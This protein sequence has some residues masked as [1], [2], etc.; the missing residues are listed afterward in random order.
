MIKKIAFYLPQFHTIP[1]NDEWWGKDFTEWTNVKKSQPQYRGHIQPE[2]P[3]NEEYYNLLD[4]EVQEKQAKLAL[5]YGID[6]F[7]YYHYWFDGKLLLEKPMENMLQNKNITLPFCICWANESWSRT[8]DGAESEVLIMQNYSDT[9]D[10]WKRHFDYLLPFFKDERYIKV[11]E[12]P[13]MI[14]YKPQ[15][16]ENLEE[17]TV[18]WNQLAKQNGFEGIHFGHQHVS[19][20]ED[21]KVIE[22][23]DFG[24]EFEPIYTVSDMYKS[25]RSKSEK[26]N[27]AITSPKCFSRNISHKYFGRSLLFDYDEVWSAILRREGRKNISPG[28]FV[29]WDNTPRRGNRSLVF[30]GANPKKFEKYFAK[31]VQRAKEEYHSDFIFI[32]AWNEWA[33]GAHLEPDEQHGYGYLEAVRAVKEE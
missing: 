8:W 31:Q 9:L 4:T 7:C 17:M 15:L 27:R 29:S 32:N 11:D 12:K 16:I 19:S 26:L 21:S 3:L 23:F 22:N 6:G 28:A 33:E 24:I 5:E 13:M 30:D 14:I 18:Y 20:F 1:E 10:G 2:V 25:T